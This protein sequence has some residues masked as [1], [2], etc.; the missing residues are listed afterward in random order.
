MTEDPLAFS[1]AYTLLQKQ[2][3]ALETTA[4]CAASVFHSHSLQ[5]DMVEKT[6]VELRSVRESILTKAGFIVAIG[7]VGAGSK[8]RQK[9]RGLEMTTLTSPSEPLPVYTSLSPSL[10]LL[11][12]GD[13]HSLAHTMCPLDCHV[14]SD[15]R[16][17]TNP[18]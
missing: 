6:P 3:T 4:I 17:E 9:W 13:L 8:L 15:P 5:V 16:T 14:Q 12:S 10:S 1:L 2:N 18:H 11:P 7:S